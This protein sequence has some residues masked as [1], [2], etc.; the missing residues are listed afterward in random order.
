MA[1]KLWDECP[2]RRFAT[3]HAAQTA[4]IAASIRYDKQL[5]VEPCGRCNGYHMRGK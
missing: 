2:R 4:C 1:K 3:L 5:W